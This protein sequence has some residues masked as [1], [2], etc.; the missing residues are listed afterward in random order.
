VP[1]RSPQAVAPGWR[2]LVARIFLEH[3]VPRLEARASIGAAGWFADEP[4]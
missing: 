3:Y 1:D 2:E 4:S